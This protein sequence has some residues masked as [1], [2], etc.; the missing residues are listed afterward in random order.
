MLVA[1]RRQGLGTARIKRFLRVICI[2]VLARG[3]ASGVLTARDALCSSQSWNS[4]P[5]PRS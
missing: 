5:C 2:K 4:C 3:I 1:M